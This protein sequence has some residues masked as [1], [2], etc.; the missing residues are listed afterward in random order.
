[1]KINAEQVVED[2]AEKDSVNQQWVNRQ[3]G[4][5]ASAVLTKQA[6]E[7]WLEKQFNI[8]MDH[9]FDFKGIRPWQLVNVTRRLDP[10]S[11]WIG[12]EFE[13]GFDDESAF[14]KSVNWLWKNADN[15][16]IDREGCGDYP[17]EF[18]FSPVNLED[19]NKKS[20]IV[21]SFIK[22]L[23]QIGEG[24][25]PDDGFGDMVGMHANF[26]GPNVRA[27]SN[28]NLHTLAA[29]LSGSISKLSEEQQMTLFGREPYGLIYA[30]GGNANPYLEGKLFNSTHSL[31]TW[32]AYKNVANNLAMLAEHLASTPSLFNGVRVFTSFINDY[33]D[34][35][36]TIRVENIFDILMGTSPVEDAS[37]C[38]VEEDEDDYSW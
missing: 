38:D 11:I 5:P 27:L 31:D 29:I 30:Q 32:R 36:A 24:D 8:D 9:G 34:D 26:S 3:L 33:E 18:T 37:M 1:M 35:I 6:V 4:V 20:Y 14:H 15:F 10:S 2:W 23:N 28:H 12:F 25:R 19:F 16:V 21:D 17:C 13:T 22:K 7:T